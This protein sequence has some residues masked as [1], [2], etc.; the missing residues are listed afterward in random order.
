MSVYER[1]AR[2]YTRG[3]YPLYSERMAETVSSVLERFGA[4]PRAIL[5][6]ACGEGTFA[7]AMAKKGFQV[8][9]VDRSSQMLKFARERAEREN[10]QVEFFLQDMRSLHFEEKFDLVTCWYDSLNYLLESKDLESTFAVVYRALRADGIFI[11]DMNT[12]YGLAVGWQRHPSLVQQDTPEI[13]EV[14]RHEYD[15]ERNLAT[16]IITGF[17]KEGN[18][19]VRIDEKHHERGYSLGDIRK[20]LKKS[21]L[22]ELS[23][24]GN[25]QEM[26]ELEPDNGR[27]YFVMKKEK[28]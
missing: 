17:V 23:C 7:V 10:V 8:T 3:P 4:R 15:F 25:L 5:D 26:S 21:R 28:G 1:F 6:M 20:C 13:F 22:K 27:V 18:K 9:G 14:H 16:A 12:I 2:F 19:W 24:W 11:F